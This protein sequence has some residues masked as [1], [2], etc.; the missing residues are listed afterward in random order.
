MKKVVSQ[1]QERNIRMEKRREGG[2]E[3][4]GE[5]RGGRSISHRKAAQP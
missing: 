5:K 1:V 3:Y 2:K 4:N